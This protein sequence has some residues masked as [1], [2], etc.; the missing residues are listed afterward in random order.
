MDKYIKSSN[1][2][3]TKRASQAH[4]IPQLLAPHNE[5]QIKVSAVKFAPIGAITRKAAAQIKLFVIKTLKA[6]MVI[7]A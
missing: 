5:P 2:S 7:D 4:Q 1:N 3:L 6:N